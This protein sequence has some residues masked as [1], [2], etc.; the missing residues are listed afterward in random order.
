MKAK[1][2]P[3]RA[4]LVAALLAFNLL[5][6]NAFATVCEVTK[7]NGGGFTTTIESVVDNCDG[8]HTIVLRVE[9]NGCGGPSC[10]ELSHYS[11]EAVPGTYSNVSVDIRSGIM[12]YDEIDMGPNLGGDPFQGFKVD[13]TSNI[14]DGDAGVFAV[15]YTLTGGLQAQQASAKAGQNRQIVSFSVADFEYVM[16]CAGSGCNEGT[17]LNGNV[18][19]DINGLTDNLVNGTG[20]QTP[21]GTAL[22]ANLL[23]ASNIVVNAM[24]VTSSGTYTFEV[25]AATYTVQ[26]STVQGTNGSAMPQTLLPSGW[27]N[28]G[29][30]VGTS[31][32]SDGTVNGL[33]SATVATGAYTENV[34]F[35]IEQ[36]PVP[37][38]NTAESQENPGGSISVPVPATTFVASDADGTV[39]SIKITAFPS[40]A[41]SITINGTLYTSGGFPAGGVLVPA[42]ENGNPTQTIS[43]DPINGVVTVSIPFIANDNANVSSISTGSANVP[44]VVTGT[45]GGLSGNVYH[46]SNGLTDDIVNGT[47]TGVAGA[48]VLYANLLNAGNQVLATMQVNANGT[49]QFSNLANGTYQVQLSTNQGVVGQQIPTTALPSGWVNT[50]EFVGIV[51][52][53][54]GTVN[55]LIQAAVANNEI[56]VNVNFGIEQ[57]PIAGTATATIQ[58]NPG[59]TITVVVPPQTFVDSDPDG[60]VQSIRLTAF[61]ANATSISVNGTAYTVTTFPGAG[62][63]IPVGSNGQPSQVI[64]VDPA[65]GA[66]T[67]PFPFKSVDNAGFESLE[68]GLANVPFSTE[69]VP[70]DNNFPATGYG[71]LAYEDLW[72]GKGDYDFN[73]LVLDYKFELISNTGNYVDIIRATFI[74]KAFGASYE[75]GFGFQLSNNIN[76]ADLYVEGYNLTESYVTLSPNGTEANQSKPTIIVYD[77]AYNQMQHPG[78]GIGVNT[79]ETAPYVTPDTLVVRIYFPENTYTYAQVDISSFNPFIMVNKDRTVEVHLPGYPPTDLA[80][81]ALFGTWEDVSDPATNTYYVN[82]HNLPWAINIY[83]SFAYPKEKQEVIWAHLKF[84]EW[85]TSSGVLFPNWYQNLAGYRNNSFIYQVLAN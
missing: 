77:N 19:H 21:G 5:A 29:E 10:K 76:A 67:V 36:R 2:L 1:L 33:L 53:N 58:Q 18:F 66:V 30:H 54:D 79:E 83:E 84:A 44:F 49:Y 78:S 23:N 39:V 9:H 38:N 71:T 56:T 42:G 37:Q 55:G 69:Y 20:I 65:D 16:T 47:G 14:G 22:Y 64:L 68:P 28:T 4:M 35:G 82:D 17:G 7:T 81:T 80:N 59:G 3:V 74:I 6:L 62:I 60:T 27:V 75:N 61:P 73:D 31:A 24:A 41:T 8:S 51:A 48:T 70:V 12:T 46:D 85:A 45:P 72:P 11:I 40:N 26:I 57:L 63:I 52:G 32:G 15:T 43:V 13:G 25:P 34:N 50:G